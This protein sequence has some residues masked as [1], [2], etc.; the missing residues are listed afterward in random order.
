MWNRGKNHEKIY[1]IKS[2]RYL[3]D[4]ASKDKNAIWK[5][6]KPSMKNE[7]DV[8]SLEK[9]HKSFVKIQ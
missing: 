5:W 7:T 2:K 6:N 3:I 4:N 1:R 9:D 8:D